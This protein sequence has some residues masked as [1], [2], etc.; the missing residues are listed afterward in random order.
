MP[1]RQDTDI[2]P[3]SFLVGDDDD[4]FSFL[5]VVEALEGDTRRLYERRDAGVALSQNERAFL[6]GK[7]KRAPHRPTKRATYSRDFSIAYF[8]RYCERLG[9]AHK[10]AVTD[11]ATA[12]SVSS[13]QVYC[14]LREIDFAFQYYDHEQGLIQTTR[15][16]DALSKEKF[17]EE[18]RKALIKA[19]ERYTD[20]SYR[21][22][23][24]LIVH[25][26]PKT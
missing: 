11:A 26:A 8:V 1:R 23:T 4:R 3:G 18:G 13:R 5:S 24:S 6:A 10:N 7:L 19:A 14:A 21:N 12:F 22:E 25:K 9:V 17:S 20:G 2:P 16:E 15:I